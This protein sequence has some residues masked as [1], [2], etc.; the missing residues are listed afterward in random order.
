MKDS[1]ADKAEINDVA[2]VEKLGKAR[3]QILDECN[4]SLVR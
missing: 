1:L 4:R 3:Q 2:A